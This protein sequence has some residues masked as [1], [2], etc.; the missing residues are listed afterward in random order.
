MPL[1]WTEPRAP[2]SGNP[3]YYDHI[4]ADTPLGPIV[5]EWKSWKDHD[6]PCGHMPWD[7]F[8]IGCNLEEAKTLVQE[9][10]DRMMPKLAD[11][12]SE[13]RMRRGEKPE[14]EDGPS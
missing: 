12:S 13:A 4:I 14:D 7:E 11:L 3:S 5:L 10:W 2:A 6:D 8:V 1:T 9:A